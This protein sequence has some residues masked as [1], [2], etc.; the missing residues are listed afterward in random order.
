MS[1]IEEASHTS[2]LD[3]ASDMALRAKRNG[4]NQLVVDYA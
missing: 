4:R 1:R 2:L 3:R